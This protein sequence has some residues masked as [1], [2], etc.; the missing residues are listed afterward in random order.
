V[1]INV[2]Y[3]GLAGAGAISVMVKVSK[4][5]SDNDSFRIESG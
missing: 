1:I 2:F 5:F 4:E 3:N